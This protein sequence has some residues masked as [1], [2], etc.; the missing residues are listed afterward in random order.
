MY[1]VNL[2][3]QVMPAMQASLAGLLE[4]RIIHPHLSWIKIVSPE[5]VYEIEPQNVRLCD[6]IWTRVFAEGTELQW[7]SYGNLMLQMSL[8]RGN[9]DTE[10]RC[11]LQAQQRGW[12]RS[13]LQRPS[14]GLTLPTSWFL[15]SRWQTL[16][17]FL[18]F[19][20]LGLRYFVMV[21]LANW[22]SL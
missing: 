22:S 13:F 1:Q 7:G 12:H 20:P 8:Q 17:K 21:A 2:A 19:K 6:F 9:L 3:I 14:K 16:N 18:L 11:H 15:T 5:F 4:I 10:R